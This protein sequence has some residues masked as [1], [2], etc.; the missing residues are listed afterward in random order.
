MRCYKLVDKA[1]KKE[2]EQI[3]RTPFV[4]RQVVTC[5][6]ED[7]R[8]CRVRFFRLLIQLIK[9]KEIISRYEVVCRL[10]MRMLHTANYGLTA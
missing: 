9:C 8:L 1:C 2:Y 4:L 3:A 5:F 6:M 10:H 7:T